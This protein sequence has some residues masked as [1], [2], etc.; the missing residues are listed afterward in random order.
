[1]E[2]RTCR[3]SMDNA[4]RDIAALQHLITVPVVDLGDRE[5]DETL[6]GIYSP[7][8]QDAVVRR[9]LTGQFLEHAQAYAN[10]YGNTDLFHRY[11][12]E[13]FDRLHMGCEKRKGLTI[14]DVGSGAGNTIFPLLSLCPESDVIATDLS[15]DLLL[16]LKNAL[17]NNNQ[18]AHCL[19]LQL[20]AEDLLLAPDTCDL[21]VGGAILHHLLSPD[22]TISACAQILKRG[23]AAI[24]FE[25]FEI[26]HSLLELAFTE[27]LR[28]KRHWFLRR[29]V[30]AF[31]HSS[32]K[33]Y[34][35]RRGSDKSLP[36]YMQID[37]KWFFTQHYFREL[38]SRHGF[39]ECT[40]YPLN[41]GA[42]PLRHQTSANLRLGANLP[43]GALPEWAWQ[44]ID[45]YDQ[46]FSDDAM[47][48][49]LL[50]GAVI[51]RK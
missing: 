19:L 31:L 36:V 16:I 12:L 32:I 51:L 45:R 41:P 26:G 18:L 25:P 10:R 6:R 20:N 50:E 38:A 30:K 9:Y 5:H 34:R 13:V 21:V 40:I 42:H 22:K 46:A 7:C 43:E 3:K 14:V 37:D 28:D 2:P 27:I 15:I 35:T 8:Y 47:K 17:V 39:S 11:L 23:G 29:Q 44:T 1:M 48:D 33:E 24:F 4:C 49:M